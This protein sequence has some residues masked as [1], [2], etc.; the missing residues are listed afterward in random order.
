MLNGFIMRK[1]SD[2]IEQ[3]LSIVPETATG[4]RTALNKKL[5]YA[6]PEMDAYH[7]RLTAEILTEQLPVPTE[8]WH[9]QLVK[10]WLNQEETE[11]VC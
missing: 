5:T 8:E 11:Q 6:A 10:I 4:L 2:V 9:H 7:W 1:L 3:I